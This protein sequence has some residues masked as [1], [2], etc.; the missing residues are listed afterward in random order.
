MFRHVLRIVL[1]IIVFDADEKEKFICE[2]IVPPLPIKRNAYRCDNKFHTDFIAN[3]FEDHQKYGIVMIEGEE[4]Q[5]YTVK[6]TS[7]IMIDHFTLHR[8]KS[9]KA[10]GQSA[11]RFNRIQ[12][13]QVA[14]YVKKICDRITTNFFTDGQPNNKGLIIAGVGGVKDDLLLSSFLPQIKILSKLTL[15][16]MDIHIVL[17]SSNDLLFEGDVN[18]EV[19]ILSSMMDLFQNNILKLVYG[20]DILNKEIEECKIKELVIIHQLK[21]NLD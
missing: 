1:R 14:E 12:K 6:G 8:Q 19:K 5:F 4:A 21:K 18:E 13:S 16:K 10:G 2:L 20:F 3:L 15:S 7:C 11:A 17:E 9:M